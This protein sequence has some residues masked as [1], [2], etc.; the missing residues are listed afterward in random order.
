MSFKRS[1]SL[2]FLIGSMLLLS[3]KSKEIEKE[4]SADLERLLSYMTGSFSSQEQAEADTNFFDM[5]LHMVQIWPRRMDG[6]WLYV[7]QA[8]VSS[9]DRPYRQR[10]YRLT[11]VN[12]STF[13]S[14]VYSINNPLHV[15][16]EWMKEKPME[17]MTPFSLSKKEGCSIILKKRGDETFSGS[18]VDKKC[19]NHLRGASY[20]T[21]EVTITGTE[22][23]SLDRGF[24]EN[25]ELVWGSEKGGYIFKKIENYELTR[26]SEN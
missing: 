26:E 16:G 8:K 6:K 3:C 12:D 19:V 10:V 1:G 7:E 24:N 25:D 21:S 23:I 5:R 2:L 20:A 22:L 14:T 4:D 15:V 11:Q 13:Q 18:T 17:H 9:L